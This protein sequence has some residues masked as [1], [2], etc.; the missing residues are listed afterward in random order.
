MKTANLQAA[1][2]EV[3]RK[4]AE[5]CNGL[6]GSLQQAVAELDMPRLKGTRSMRTYQGFLT[7][8]D[9]SKF[10]S[11]MAI[12]VERYARTMIQMPPSASTF[13]LKSD[14]GGDETQEPMM[15]GHADGH[16]GDGLAGVQTL[17]AYQVKD[18]QAPGGK[19]D[20]EREA[21]A[22]GFEY[23]QTVVPVSETDMN[24]FVMET[25]AAYDILGFIPTESVRIRLTNAIMRPRSLPDFF[26]V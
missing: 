4:L 18:D 23:G 8:G 14:P 26:T 12:D 1:N 22:K 24:V 6:I 13:V 7:L 2:E 17:R 20:V 16:A 3:L 9:S 5:G 21:L 15:N 10:E 19:R 25:E 11:A